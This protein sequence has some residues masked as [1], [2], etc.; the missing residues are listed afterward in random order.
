[1]CVAPC[2]IVETFVICFTNLAA[3]GAF[4]TPPVYGKTDCIQQ[5]KGIMMTDGAKMEE[6]NSV[7]MIMIIP[8][9]FCAYE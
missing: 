4:P 7:D 1:M 3:V 9:V 5:G 8:G 6:K 2:G